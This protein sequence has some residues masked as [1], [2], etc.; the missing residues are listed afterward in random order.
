MRADGGRNAAAEAEDEREDGYGDRG[1][2][3][4]DGPAAGDRAVFVH[5]TFRG[6]GRDRRDVVELPVVGEQAGGRLADAEDGA[7][8]AEVAVGVG[9]ASADEV[10]PGGGEVLGGRRE[11]GDDLEAVLD[12]VNVVGAE[13]VA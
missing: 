9:G 13:P 4:G 6:R 3:G 8:P 11:V 2:D 5:P 10:G 7:A 1:E 12:E